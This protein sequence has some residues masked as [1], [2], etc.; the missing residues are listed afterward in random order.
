MRFATFIGMPPV[1]PIEMALPDNISGNSFGPNGFRIWRD[2]VRR[3]MPERN[4]GIY[5]NFSKVNAARRIGDAS[6]ASFA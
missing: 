1:N 2:L 3:G 6:A 5:D 4:E